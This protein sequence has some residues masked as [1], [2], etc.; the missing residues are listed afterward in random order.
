MKYLLVLFSF[1]LLKPL[2]GQV[3]LYGC[4]WKYYD[5]AMAPPNQSSTTW[6]ESAYNDAS[7]NSGPSELGYGDGDEATVISSSTLTG[8]YRFTF[9]VDDPADFSDLLMQLTYD[10]GAVIYLNGAE[11]W[12]VNMPNGTISYNTFASST[13][14]DNAQASLTITNSLVTGTNVVAVEVHQRSASSTDLSFNF[15]MTGIPAPGVAVVTRGPYLQKANDTSVVVRWRTNLET[16]SKIDYGTSLTSL[17]HTKTINTV[18]TE[19]VV[20]LDSLTAATKYFYRI[21]TLTD[22]IV[23]PSS[24]TYFKTYPVTGT[25]TPLTAWIIGDCG[26]AN[27]DARNVRNAYYDFIGSGHTDMMMFLGDNAY[28][29]GVDTEYQAAIFQNMYGEKLKNTIAW[30]CI[31]NH[32]G[33]SANSNAQTGP[34]Y[35]IFTFPKQGECGGVASG[36]EAYYSF[37]FGN[38][39]FIVLDSYETDRSV[40]GPMYNWLEDDLQTTTAYWIVGVWHHPPYS[41]GSHNSDTSTELKQMRENFLPLLENYGVDLV[42]SGHSHSYERTFLLNGHYGLSSTFNPAIHT[43]GT[44][45]SGSGQTENAT[46]Y[47]KA[48][49]GM[50]DGKG[51]VYVV[52]GSAGKKES[53]AMDHPAMYFDEVQLGSCVL[54]IN[55]DT[56]TIKFLRQTGATDDHFTLIKDSGCVIGSTCNDNDTCTINDVV[57][58][59]CYC[60]G[61]ANHRYVSNSNDLGT[62]SL[63]DA[64][65]HACTGDTIQFL[66]SVTDTIRI[67]SD[68][69]INKSLVLQ[70][71]PNQN[72]VISGQLQTRIFN[73]LSASQLTLSRITLYGG[74][75]TTEGGALLNNGTLILENATFKNNWQGAT[76][77]AWTNHNMISVKI[78]TTYLRIN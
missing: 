58:N 14:N 32:D 23:F 63:R 27:N 77:R 78:G 71:F 1:F 75:E 16:I 29:D 3:I 40:G 67:T 34:Y 53:G 20:F 61:E 19:H 68:I 12:R 11:V 49:L 55:Q 36:T 18:T 44:T 22:T 24:S 8:Y 46:A 42:L 28:V 69:N 17:N 48:P 43:V 60:R 15:T 54:K 45:G 21:R 65:T 38:V 33:H 76:P 25:S 59:Y 4:D 64:I 73:L 7:W 70:A 6:K 35:D 50:E 74:K 2:A 56:L 41:K 30:S 57:D 52:T 9:Y 26:T 47:Y 66:A 51:A 39:H 13:S 31:G 37:D 5:L 72:I 62:G 10:D